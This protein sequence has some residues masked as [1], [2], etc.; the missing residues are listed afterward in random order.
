MEDEEEVRLEV[1]TEGKEL[2]TREKTKELLIERIKL[3]FE[4]EKKL[5]SM[6][7]MS[8]DESEHYVYLARQQVLDQIYIQHEIKFTDFNRALK[9]YDDFEEDDDV[10]AVEG[11]IMAN[12]EQL[13]K[14][15]HE[16]FKKSMQLSEEQNKQLREMCE[17]ASVVNGS[18]GL[19]GLLA[20]EEYLKLFK[21]IVTLQCRF[22]I[23]IGEANKAARRAALVNDDKASFAT[24]TSQ[25]LD[26]I[27][28]TKNGVHMGVLEFFKIEPDLYDK[29]GDQA[30]D[31]EET[32]RNVDETA[33]KI[34]IA[35]H[36]RI[37]AQDEN[38]VELDRAT[39]LKHLDVLETKKAQFLSGIYIQLELGQFPESHLNMAIE[40][41]RI[42]ATDSYFND[43]GIS[44]IQISIAFKT[45]NLAFEEDFGNIVRKAEQIISEAVDKA[46]DE[47]GVPRPSMHQGSDEDLPYEAYQ[48]EEPDLDM[49]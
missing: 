12:R 14:D 41:A 39:V 18:P 4:N 1:D 17:A 47:A 35:E 48:E 29:T 19:N 7:P 6:K 24:I 22:T 36:K 10:K 26:L 15:Q 46:C 8:P 38:Y 25:Q 43:C 21:L 32:G 2:L 13:K 44:D 42:Q 30:Q 49:Y 20:F 23:Q 27:N 3:D 11:L 5:N 9:V 28:K 34:E 33:R 37:A 31:N 16:E 45:F 40:M